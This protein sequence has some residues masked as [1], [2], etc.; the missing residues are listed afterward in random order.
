MRLRGEFEEAL[1]WLEHA[2][3]QRNV[4]I[5]VAAVKGDPAFARYTDDPRYRAW[6]RKVN[7]PD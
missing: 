2:S 4:D 3:A 5:V 6:L 1:K 7:L